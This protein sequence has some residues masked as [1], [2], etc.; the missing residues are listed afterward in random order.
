MARGTPTWR[1]CS[2]SWRRCPK[3]RFLYHSRR[4]D[5]SRWLKARTEFALAQRLRPV[6]IKDFP[7]TEALRQG[8]LA[9]ISQYRFEQGQHIVAEFDRATFDFASDFYRIGG[10]SIGG[11]A[12]GSA[13]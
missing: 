12:R 1:N 13:P 4:N 2:R 11:K 8:L 3:S 5:F 9:A 7:S 6:T 10:G